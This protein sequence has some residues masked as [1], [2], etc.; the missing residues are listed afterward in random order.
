MSAPAPRAQHTDWVIFH[1]SQPPAELVRFGP[2]ETTTCRC[3][4]SDSSGSTI[5]WILWNSPRAGRAYLALC[6][7]CV[8]TLRVA[9]ELAP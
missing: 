8:R 5:E 1:V 4:E 2:W 7:E 9:L 6:E 3:C